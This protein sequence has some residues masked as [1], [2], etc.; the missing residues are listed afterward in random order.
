MSLLA[1]IVAAPAPPENVISAIA[2]SA[3][4]DLKKLVALILSSKSAFRPDPP[5]SFPECQTVPLTPSA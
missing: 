4:S 3:L 5:P 1:A 2:V